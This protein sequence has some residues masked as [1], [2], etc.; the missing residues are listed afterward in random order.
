M[1]TISIEQGLSQ[2]FISGICQDSEGF[3]WFGTNSGLN[4]YDGY[5][6]LIF[7]H[8]PY[9]SHSLSNN[10]IIAVCEAGEFLCVV[11]RGGIDLY[12]RR[13]RRF[14]RLSQTSGLFAHTAATLIAESPNTVWISFYQSD[15]WH[16]Y[17]LSWPKHLLDRLAQG[18]TLEELTRFEPMFEG[19][20]LNGFD[21]S[22]D[23][24][25][26]WVTAEGGRLFRQSL[27]QGNLEEIPVPA[28]A[29]GLNKFSVIAL[30]NRDVCIR[31]GLSK[32]LA[33]YD[34]DAP[35]DRSW[36][37]MPVGNI[38]IVNF[39][40][41]DPARDLLWAA[42]ENE[43]WGFDLQKTTSAINRAGARFV[44]AVP[45]RAL[46]GFTDRSGNLWICTNA[47]GIRKFN[48]QTGI[49]KNYAD[50]HSVYCKPVADRAGNI[51]LGNL[52]TDR[53]NYRLSRADGTL[54]PHPLPGLADNH[55]ETRVVAD[56]S[57]TLWFAGATADTIPPLL[58]RFS[59]P[60]GNYT[61]FRYPAKFDGLMPALYYDPAEHAI[62][63]AHARQLFRFDIATGAFS[64]FAFDSLQLGRSWA[65]ALTK[66]ADGSLW[67][68]LENGLL[69]AKPAGGA[70]Q[71]QL[72]K[73]DPSD[74]N[75]L[76]GNSIKSLLTDPADGHVLWIGTAGQGLSRYD[77][78][79]KQ[80]Q[81]YDT[82]TGLSDDVVYGI[83]AENDGAAPDGTTLWLSTN[84]GLNRFNPATGAFRYFVKSDGLQDDEFNTFACGKT[85]DGS[86]M[87]GG[88][89][90]LTVFDP[91]AL[92]A[93]AAPARVRFSAL[94]V[95]DQT[96]TPRD[97][98]GILR[99]GIEY[100]SALNLPYHQ[101]NLT[102]RFMAEDLTQPERNQFSF[103]LEGAENEWA[104]TGFDNSAQYLNLAPGNYMFKVKAANSDG[105]WN[106]TPTILKIRIRPPWYASVWAYLAYALLLGSGAYFFYRFQLDKKLE[107]AENERLKELDQVKTRLYTNITH[108]FRTPLTVILG[109]TDQI[110]QYL[111]ARSD[112][113]VE[114]AVEMIRRNGQ[115]LLQLINQVL[116][117]SK[118]ESGNM[119]LHLIRG[120]I[121]AYL[122]YLVESF[123]SYAEG[124]NIRLH[125]ESAPESLDMAYDREKLQVI[126]SNLLSNAIKFTPAGGTVSVQISTNDASGTFITHHSSFIS[127]RVVDTGIGIP[128]EK[129]P[130]IFDRFFQVDNSSTRAGA[131]TGIGLALVK[132]L[133][134]LMQGHIAVDSRPG[135]GS[136][137][138]V[139]LPA[140]QP[141]EALPADPAMLPAPAI[142]VP[143]ADKVPAA[144]DDA[145]TSD[146]PFALVV[147]DNADVR[148]YL[149]Q[150]LKDRYRIMEA[151]DGPVGIELALE[152]IPDIIV[153]DVM[154]P[155]K[156]GFEVC[157][158]LK[159]DERTSHIPVV[160]LTARAA[161]ED[162]IAGLR[163]GADAYLTKPFHREELAVV[164]EQLLENRRR[165]RMRYE[166][167][168]L[169]NDTAAAGAPP[170][171][172]AVVEDAF[173][174]KLR[175][176]VEAHLSDA[177]FD[178]NRLSRLV[179]MSHSQIFRKLKALTGRSPSTFI[180]SV[181]LSHARQL[182]KTTAL[183]VAEIAYETGFTS[184]AYF[185]TVFVE[186]FGKTPTEFR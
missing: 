146:K 142:F 137:F 160:L 2:G 102:I 138:T 71:F 181:R 176:I 54:N 161:V 75:S 56:S 73:N 45:E 24:K 93:G 144:P 78:R 185:S 46:R 83:L 97:A 184:P 17:R 128:E 186:E 8:D 143:Q 47:K 85:P 133:V 106:G 79:T 100:T 74:R 10:S 135:A 120:D 84:K 122:K 95:N 7:K 178:M 166:R 121:L 156:D 113:V 6:F 58:I 30:G 126:V 12:H 4:R 139:T 170:D 50:K 90:G 66:T 88:V 94:K 38:P 59:P 158:A 35:P 130:H 68:A 53:Y 76:P 104:H 40:A 114:T 179:G 29:S 115:Q 22:A 63:T 86:L 119:R 175:D 60:A 148:R 157:D 81:N 61:R 108:E 154:M 183:T 37:T 117:L 11:T 141:A 69:Q 163:R 52:Q 67:L 101:N 42:T 27:P 57:G 39:L 134:K 150:C 172:I 36:Q 16:L 127:I 151:H 110:K 145:G 177:E 155:G 153:S 98:S 87:F 132:E 77:L 152:H 1:Q 33:W 125:F 111:A 140:T 173:L 96:I 123:Q 162:R 44:L 3:M 174:Q 55:Y 92:R 34:S 70:F 124:K 72:L 168:I 91:K 13:T 31:D 25:T 19:L 65:F 105:V 28:S 112:E 167:G 43:A 136:M 15:A 147:E 51:W 107:H 49:F 5:D 129:L 116:D 64:G 180:R 118:L 21:L 169:E 171:E 14:F 41:F 103:F 20:Q 131:G 109:M 99:E 9:D 32:M 149:V 18:R 165:L 182:L 62:W 164:L 80:F 159:N 26:L 89:N 23:K 48:P 82:R